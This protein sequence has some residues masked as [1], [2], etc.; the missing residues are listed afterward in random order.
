MKFVKEE[1]GYSPVKDASSL[2]ICRWALTCW[3]CHLTTILLSSLS[4]SLV[5]AF[6]TLLFLL[7][8]I[9]FSFILSDHHLAQVVQPVIHLVHLCQLLNSFS[10]DLLVA[11]ALLALD[12]NTQLLL[13]LCALP[14]N[15][16]VS[17]LCKEHIVDI[18]TSPEDALIAHSLCWHNLNLV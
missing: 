3:W 17:D 15:F 1:M 6:L 9:S 12:L 16:V 2:G 5:D 11:F 7:L 14:T 4:H 8:S 13:H 18:N 10:Y